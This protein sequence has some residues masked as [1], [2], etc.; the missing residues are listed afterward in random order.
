MTAR[1]CDVAVIGAGVMGSA[2][3][4]ELAGRGLKTLVLEKSIPGAEASSAAAG[5][6][7][8]QAEAPGPGS[9]AELLLRSRDL[10]AGFIDSLETQTGIATGYR[11]C[12]SLLVAFD[13]AEKK[14]LEET[15]SWQKESGL[16]AEILDGKQLRELEPNLSS[17]A[18]A[19]LLFSQ[20]GQIEPPLLARALSRGAELAGCQFIRT[21]VRAIASRG[22]KVEGI[23]TADGP[24]SCGRA[25]LAAGAWTCQVAGS[26]LPA[27]A[28]EPV[29]GQIVQ[30]EGRAGL[31]GRVLVR[32]G[33]GY[34]VPRADGRVLAGSTAERAG[35]EKNVTAVGVRSILDLAVTLSPCLAQARF[36]QAWANFRPATADL[37]PI[38]GEGPLAGLFV[39]SG[40]FRNGILLTPVTAQSLA[41]MVLGEA[42]PAG[43]EPFSPRRLLDA[44]V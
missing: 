1:T 40:H 30:L 9:F 19:G 43:L 22:G 18:L 16:A 10:Y 4:R 34:L 42:P 5:I 32:H 25:V 24:I 31:L 11:R 21:Q 27:D 28:V 23:E 26:G 39:A 44:S 20:D 35:F 37:L 3:A 14:Y 15:L 13:A 8:A 2:I 6:L 36:D 12:G 17:G 33:K 29:R 38:L 7:G 41:A